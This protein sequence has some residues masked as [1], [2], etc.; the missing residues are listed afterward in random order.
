ML[1]LPSS[2]PCVSMVWGCLVY[3]CSVRSYAVLVIGWLVWL[4]AW[5]VV[6]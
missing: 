1:L 5:F 2:L 4:V 6:C 3:C